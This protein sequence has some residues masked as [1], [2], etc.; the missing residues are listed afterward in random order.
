[1][2]VCTSKICINL[3]KPGHQTTIFYQQCMIITLFH[4]R[5]QKCYSA[6]VSTDFRSDH[7]L[8][9][10]FLCRLSDAMKPSDSDLS[11][12]LTFCSLQCQY[13]ILSYG[14]KVP[15][16]TV[17]TKDCHYVC[18][19]CPLTGQRTRLQAIMQYVVLL[20]WLLLSCKN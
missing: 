13:V 19:T 16:M 8:I 10:A 4:K 11:R 17:K 20:T 12:M 1:M 2:H 15:I 6:N 14:P 9:F 3:Y 18:S 5:G 7:V